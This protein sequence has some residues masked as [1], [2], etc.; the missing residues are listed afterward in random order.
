MANQLLIKNT[1]ADM[2]T[3]SAA[4]ITG[5]QQK[6]IKASVKTVKNIE[7]NYSLILLIQ[8]LAMP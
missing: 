2:R 6:Y 8:L 7:S 4:E 5:L 1:M 3:L